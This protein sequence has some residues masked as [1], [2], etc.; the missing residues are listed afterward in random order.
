MLGCANGFSTTAAGKVSQMA[1]G[2]TDLKLQGNEYFRKWR[3]L[4][5]DFVWCIDLYVW[6]SIFNLLFNCFRSKVLYMTNVAMLFSK[7]Q[8]KVIGR[9][10][11]TGGVL[12]DT[13]PKCWLNEQDGVDL[14]DPSVS[15]TVYWMSFTLFQLKKIIY[16]FWKVLKK[17]TI[18][19]NCA[20]PFV[21]LIHCIFYVDVLLILSSF[22]IVITLFWYEQMATKR[23]IQI[24]NSR[25][26]S[27]S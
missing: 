5:S 20:K 7:G 16:R 8:F 11:W 18:A 27:D 2:S 14:I 10:C 12:I 17:R 26:K 4:S 19:G 13:T 3:V 25:F 21:C 22:C 15:N 9:C 6:F 23:F 24:F 1:Q